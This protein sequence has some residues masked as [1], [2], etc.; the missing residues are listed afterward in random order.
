MA[1]NANAAET[2]DNPLLAHRF[3]FY[4][5]GFFPQVSSTIQLDGKIIGDGNTI[6]FENAFGLEDSKS[7]L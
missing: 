7:V 5:G 1:G 3:A 6:S 2:A 4:L